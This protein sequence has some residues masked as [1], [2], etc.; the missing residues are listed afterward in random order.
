MV[1]VHRLRKTF[2]LFNT[3][4]PRVVSQRCNGKQDE[5]KIIGRKWQRISYRRLLWS[6]LMWVP[7]CDIKKQ[8][9]RTLSTL[10]GNHS[11]EIKLFRWRKYEW[12]AH[13]CALFYWDKSNFQ[14][15]ELAGCLHD[16]L[17]CIRLVRRT[18]VVG[19]IRARKSVHES[20]HGSQVQ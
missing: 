2:G 17:R 19:Y 15:W 13:C 8:F 6:G 3:N 11:E 18:C 9:I 12:L 7:L 1:I 14:F 4:T 20:M 5:N 16:V 10:E